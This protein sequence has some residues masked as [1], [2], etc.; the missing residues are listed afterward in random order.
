MNVK[1]W[2]R[3]LEA[4]ISNNR[5]CPK[6]EQ[7]APSQ[8]AISDGVWERA[9]CTSHTRREPCSECGKEQTEL[10]FTFA[11]NSPRLAGETVVT[12]NN[13]GRFTDVN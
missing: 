7:S 8:I 13:A 5:A 4:K 10:H 6:C 9:D 3:K 11:L 12:P 1:N 2:L